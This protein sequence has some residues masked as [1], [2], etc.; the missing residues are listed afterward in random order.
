MAL[1]G[2]AV[3]AQRLG[4]PTAHCHSEPG[5]RPPC[6]PLEGSTRAAAEEGQQ[7]S[8]V[9]QKATVDERGYDAHGYEKGD[10][11]HA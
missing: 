1:A 5:T 11:G 9:L 10:S 3:Q 7:G 4:L 6:P 8:L 2:A